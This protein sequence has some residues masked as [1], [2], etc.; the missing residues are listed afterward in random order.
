MMAEMLFETLLTDEKHLREVVAE[1]RSRLKVRLMSA[2]HQAAAGRAAAQFSKS[3][4]LN[5]RSVGLGY[6][7]YLVQLDEHFDEEK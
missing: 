2:G 4:W 3:S 1:S 5:D 7:D 6:Y